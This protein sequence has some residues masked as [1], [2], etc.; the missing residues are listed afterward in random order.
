MG[1]PPGIKPG[2]ADRKLQGFP[3]ADPT[4]LLPEQ[5][6]TVSEE[7]NFSTERLKSRVE[8]NPINLL[9]LGRRS[10]PQSS[11]NPKKKPDLRTREISQ[12]PNNIFPGLPHPGTSYLTDGIK[13]EKR[14]FEKYVRRDGELYKRGLCSSQQEGTAGL[15]AGQGCWSKTS[16]RIAMIHEGKREEA[17]SLSNEQLF[18]LTRDETSDEEPQER[19]DEHLGVVEL[20]NTKRGKVVFLEHVDIID[21]LIAE[22]LEQLI[23]RHLSDLIV[24]SALAELKAAATRDEITL[25][26]NLASLIDTT[27]NHGK[28]IFKRHVE[29]T[30]EIQAKR[31]LIGDVLTDPTS[32]GTE[33]F[34]KRAFFTQSSHVTKLKCLGALCLR[35]DKSDNK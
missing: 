28:T 23:E 21:R 15:G 20:F 33:I 35:E 34:Q 13:V 26:D 9:P 2:R 6:G 16:S 12:P 22:E 8:P 4:L 24:S 7:P 30:E 29:E 19:D 17:E 27:S 32:A 5:A 25:A 18:V 10:T 11:S 1:L 14:A 31:E 3:S